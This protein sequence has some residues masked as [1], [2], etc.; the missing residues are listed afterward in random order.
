MKN[1]KFDHQQIARLLT[2]GT[3]QMDGE[4]A[5]ALNRASA[6]ALQ[7]QRV[8]EPV[9]SLH[10]I[11]HR[12]HNLIPHS[13]PQ[14]FATVVLLATIAI[15]VANY[16]QTTQVPLDIDILTDDLPIEVFVDK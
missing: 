3:E 16:W 15:G 14:W 9:F 2:R 4:I 12:A 7:K 8:H 1:P 5:S 11:G 13:R 10:A 6:I